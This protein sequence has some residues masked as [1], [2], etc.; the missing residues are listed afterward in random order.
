MLSLDT[1]DAKVKRENYSLFCAIIK[2]LEGYQNKDVEEIFAFLE[3]LYGRC[4]W[5]FGFLN[6]NEALEIISNI[7]V[8][9]GSAIVVYAPPI[10]KGKIHVL[11]KSSKKHIGKKLAT[12]EVVR[13]TDNQPLSYRHFSILI[14][15]INDIISNAQSTMKINIKLDSKYHPGASLEYET[16]GVSSSYSRSLTGAITGIGDM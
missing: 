11:I 2:D 8:S 16:D 1:P 13:F 6:H 5:W 10:E 15:S 12:V 4:S 7:N 14:Q 9:L 3:I